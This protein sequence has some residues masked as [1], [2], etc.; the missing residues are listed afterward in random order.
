MADE[1]S[2]LEMAEYILQEKELKAKLAVVQQKLQAPVA[3]LKKAKMILAK[4]QAAYD[5][6]LAE[7]KPLLSD[8]TLLEGELEILEGK[9][10]RL[11][12]EARFAE[13][14]GGALR[15][16]TQEFVQQMSD[17]VGDPAELEAKKAAKEMAADQALA[18]LKAEMGK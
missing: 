11:R 17:L 13:G 6:A 5:A 12:Q 4:A 18:A 15:P 16:G 2:Q 7:V 1:G 9:K 14:G 3:K 10:S 8:K